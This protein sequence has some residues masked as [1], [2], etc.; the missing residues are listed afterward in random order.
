MKKGKGPLTFSEAGRRAETAGKKKR[1]LNIHWAGKIL[2]RAQPIDTG[3]KIG[4]E[5][6]TRTCQRGKGGT[7]SH[8][9]VRR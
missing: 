5:E 2:A 4:E 1:I 9:R 8:G 6:G 3:R 7:T